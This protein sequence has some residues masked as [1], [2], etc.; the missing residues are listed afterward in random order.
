[1]SKNPYEILADWLDV[2][3]Q[4]I[5]VI[6]KKAYAALHDDNDEGLYRDFMRSKALRL[7]ALAEDATEFAAALDRRDEESVMERINRF[8]LSA[9]KSL[10]FGSVFFMSALLYPDDYNEGDDND[11]EIF[12]ATVRDLG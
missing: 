5:R 6:E 4:E 9:S 12:A 8:S 1:M 11:L 2:Q 3:A 7:A 10:E